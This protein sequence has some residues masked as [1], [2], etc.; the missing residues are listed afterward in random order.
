MGKPANKA[1]K[2]TKKITMTIQSSPK[3]GEHNTLK[4]W[5][6]TTFEYV[7]GEI[8]VHIPNIPAWVCPEDGEVSFTPET[9]DELIPTVRELVEVARKARERRS[10]L[11]EYTIAVG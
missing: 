1:A 5:R 8:K 6:K 3:C 9:V 11:T 7:D 10:V 2:T 4:E